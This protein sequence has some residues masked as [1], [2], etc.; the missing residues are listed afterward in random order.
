M[1]EDVGGKLGGM[2]LEGDSEVDGEVVV[3]G[4]LDLVSLGEM[5]KLGDTDGSSLGWVY[6]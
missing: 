6:R 5:L 2:A 4:T 3:D 1:G